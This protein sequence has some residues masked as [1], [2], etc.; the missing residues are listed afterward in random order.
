MN[1]ITQLFDIRYPIIQAGMVWCSGSKLAAAVSNRGGLGIV[2]AGSMKPDL[3]D[4]HLRKMKT[5]TDKPYAVNL[6]IFSKYAEDQVRVMIEND[7]KIVFSSAGSPKK[8]TPLF[9]EH[10]M[11]VV[12]VVPS[13]KLAQKCVDA[14]VDAVVAEGFEAGGHNGPDETT[15]LVLIPEVVDAVD[16]PVIAAGG[17]AN[18]RQIAAC[19]ALGASAVQ[20]G[21]RFAITVE[22]SAHERFKQRVVNAGPGETRLLMKSLMPVRML[23]NAFMDDVV[24]A[25]A[26]GADRERLAELLG[27]GRAMKGI[28]EGDL[29]Q[30]ELEIGQVSGQITDIPTVAELMTRLISEYN[31]AVDSLHGWS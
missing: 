21:S 8:Y 2:G 22:S 6:P 12:H 31:A 24:A 30:G 10:G 27:K 28:F 4:E 18:G 19:M 23:K 1:R 20:I 29:D 3:L 25:E 15:T 14:G 26:T 11:T 7:V 16:V 13:A 17:I 9:K 5:L